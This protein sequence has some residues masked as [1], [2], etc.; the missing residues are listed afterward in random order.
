VTDHVPPARVSMSNLIAVC[1]TVQTHVVKFRPLRPAFEGHS[2]S[3]KWHRSIAY[4][5][6]RV[7][8]PILTMGLS[9]IVSEIIG[10]FGRKRRFFYPQCPRRLCV[11]VEFC[12]GV[13]AKRTRLLVLPTLL[14]KILTF[15]RKTV[16]AQCQHWT[17]IHTHRERQTIKN[18]HTYIQT[19]RQ[20]DW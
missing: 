4:L 13:F 10:D 6:F 12:N 7:S 14:L 11:T 8:D 9:R 18:R 3:S 19:D 5:W 20:T 15:E 17:H 1:Q 2:R 16:F